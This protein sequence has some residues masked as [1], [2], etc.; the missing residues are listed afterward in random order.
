[1]NKLEA[2]LFLLFCVV[3]TFILL[4]VSISFKEPGIYLL[5][6]LIV[7]MK[8]IHGHFLWKNPSEISFFVL[9][10]FNVHLLKIDWTVT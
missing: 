6:L 1:M 2:L 5:F 7:W 10:H 9:F 4:S 3:M 8:S